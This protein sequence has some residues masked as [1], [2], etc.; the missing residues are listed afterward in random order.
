MLF[1]GNRG[2]FEILITM[3][4]ITDV[5]D[6]SK[7]EWYCSILDGQFKVKVNLMPDLDLRIEWYP[8]YPDYLSMPSE[9]ADLGKSQ[10][11]I[12]MY[13]VVN[14]CAKLLGQEFVME[15]QALNVIIRSKG[16]AVN[17]IQEDS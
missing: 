16:E 12:F 10:Y 11:L 4:K 9:A 13:C 1:T 7:R 3:N 8:D 15:D 14:D 2:L 17:F 5:N 6:L